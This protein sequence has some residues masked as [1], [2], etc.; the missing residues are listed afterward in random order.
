MYKPT[1]YLIGACCPKDINSPKL[2]FYYKLVDGFG[3]VLD[4][5]FRYSNTDTPLSHNKL[6]HY[7]DAIFG[8]FLSYGLYSSRLKLEN[9]ETTNETTNETINET[10]IYALTYTSPEE[11]CIMAIS[12]NKD[13]FNKTKY[14]EIKKTIKEQDGEYK[15]IS[16]LLLYQRDVPIDETQYR[17]CYILDNEQLILTRFIRCKADHEIVLEKKHNKLNCEVSNP[18]LLNNIYEE[19]VMNS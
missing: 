14:D 5:Q 17:V 12:D 1:A 4:I 18:L 7:M 11:T 13:E 2:G 19:G 6:P 16:S 15:I 9:N 8:D 3:V 10:Y